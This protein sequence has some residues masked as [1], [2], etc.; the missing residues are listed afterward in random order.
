MNYLGSIFDLDGVLVDTADY[1]FE[2][3]KQLANRLKIP[4]SKEDNEHLKGVSREASLDILL[5]RG[6]NKYSNDEK[7]AFAHE[8]NRIYVDF[9]KQMTPS[10][11]LPGVQECLVELKNKNVKIALG[12]ASKNAKII[13]ELTDLSKYFDAIVDGN[14]TSKAKPDP[15]VFLLAAD[16]L[17]LNPKKC[18]VF[19]DAFAG[20]QA[21]KAANMYCVGIG[22]RKN[23]PYADIVITDFTEI[24]I[25]DVF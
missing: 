6:T 7:I 3:W 10:N 8:K 19:E 12:S 18:V 16:K 25:N 13:L 1:H 20:T 14:D 11:V 2:A 23:L 5:S 21:A 22:Q 24:K 9:I 17:G 4:F 15:E